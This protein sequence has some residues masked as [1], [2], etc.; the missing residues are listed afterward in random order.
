MYGFLWYFLIFDYLP[1]KE[2]VSKIRNDYIQNEC[3]SRNEWEVMTHNP[4]GGVISP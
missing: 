2:D 4:D 3:I 1:N